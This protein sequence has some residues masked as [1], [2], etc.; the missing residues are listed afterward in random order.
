MSKY[1]EFSTGNEK[2]RVE[3]ELENQLLNITN[4]KNQSQNFGELDGLD[5]RGSQFGF[6]IEKMG[7]F[8]NDGNDR[9]DDKTVSAIFNDPRYSQKEAREGSRKNKNVINT[10]NKTLSGLDTAKYSTFSESNFE[11]PPQFR[12][13]TRGM[14]LNANPLVRGQGD[15]TI[16]NNN[17]ID[18]FKKQEQFKQN[19]KQPTMIKEEEEDEVEIDMPDELNEEEMRKKQMHLQKV[20]EQQLPEQQKQRE[21]QKMREVPNSEVQMEMKKQNETD[22]ARIIKK[23][24]NIDI[25]DI[26]LPAEETKPVQRM[27]KKNITADTVKGKILQFKNCDEQLQDM[28][29]HAFINIWAEDFASKN[30]TT[31]IG[32]KQFILDNFKDKLNAFFVLFDD[33]GDF[34]STF[35]VDVE[36]FA[37]FISHIFVNP[38]LRNKGF[39][40]KTIKY[41]E[42]Y[43]KKLG[44]NA[45]NLWCEEHLVPFYRKQGYVIESKIR[46]SET[47]EVWKMAIN[48][49]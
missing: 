36:N 10:T 11:D 47:K 2:T 16:N 17:P 38:T 33:E 39:G 41:G 23:I 37:P 31:Y 29:S 12:G 48:L 8:N 6:E 21:M 22:L 30:I 7:G 19:L 26:D 44:F 28:I 43:I 46:I 20:R 49:D 9:N 42:K 24:K 32:V 1:S 27:P 13:L 5:K 34:I 3:G 40:K 4:Y 25:T 35:A 15:V 18:K 45:S 14:E